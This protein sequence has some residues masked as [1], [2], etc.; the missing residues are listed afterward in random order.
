[1]KK[2][3]KL[4]TGILAMGLA[5]SMTTF[6]SVTFAEEA[7]QNGAAIPD[8]SLE[9]ADSS[10]EP[11]IDD[12]AG[13]PSAQTWPQGPEITSEAAVVMEDTTGTVLYSKNPDVQI[14]PGSPVKIMTVLVALEN[15]Q[16]S[17][18]VNVTST[19]ASA[20]VDGSAN[21][22]LQEGETLTLEDCLHGIMLA[23][24][25]D[26]A[27]Q[28]AKHI[29]G[30]VDAFVEKMNARAKELGCTSTVFANP[31]GLPDD[32]QH[33]TAKD[34]ALI[35]KAALDNETFR[36][37][38]TAATYTINATDYSSARE[39]TNNFA[40][41][42]NSD[43]NY[44]EGC[45]GGKEG[46]TE[47][48]LSTLACGATRN[49]MT[50]IAVVLQGENIQTEAE[51]VT[52]LDHGFSNFHLVNVSSPEDTLSGGTALLP[53][54]VSADQ[55]AIQE[56][57]QADGT[58]QTFYFDNVEV[59]SAVIDHIEEE[60]PEE[61]NIDGTANLKAAQDLSANKSMTPY[62][63]I[64]GVG[65]VLLAGLLALMVKIIKS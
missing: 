47:E 51:A 25:N 19:G 32:S 45:L 16:L 9:N 20:V 41:L 46:Y 40:L 2:R 13:N 10:Q 22:N 53:A 18:Q 48:S 64:A 8:E 38:S 58:H 37:I 5:L 27:L 14:Q 59:G 39:L 33:T 28:V 35:T 61:V 60:L 54:S 62:Y 34:M 31:T 36:K 26:A 21:I 42:Q 23:S 11:A 1:M 12:T 52:L 17:D 30:S 15:G 57:E 49:D 24:A 55:V 56:S 44:Y 50:L 7:A 3:Q 4:L 43:A 29:S 65:V 63:I 6:P